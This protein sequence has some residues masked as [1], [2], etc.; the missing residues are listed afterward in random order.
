MFPLFPASSL[1]FLLFPIL[2]FLSSSAL[3]LFLYSFPFFIISLQLS[4]FPFLFSCP[5]FPFFPLPLFLLNALLFCSS[6]LFTVLVF[7]FRN[8]I[9]FSPSYFSVPLYDPIFSSSF[10]L[11]EPPFIFLAYVA[12]FLFMSSCSLIRP[13][14]I[15]VFVPSSLF[16]SFFVLIRPLFIFIFSLF[17]VLC[18][19][20]PFPSS[21]AFPCAST[22]LT[23]PYSLPLPLDNFG[24][25]PLNSSTSLLFFFLLF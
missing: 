20:F 11:I 6:S 16:F 7:V 17:S 8:L 13:S 5:F 1:L 14:S 22:L 23:L 15:S 2:L 9:C 24:V 25:T 3:H 10:P 12:L 19:H 4:V 21:L 18:S